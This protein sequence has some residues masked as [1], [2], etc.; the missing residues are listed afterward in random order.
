MARV[1]FVV[2]TTAE[3]TKAG[4]SQAPH[5]APGANRGWWFGDKVCQLMLKKIVTVP[6]ISVA[7]NLQS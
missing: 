2:E 4:G 1:L 3:D 6:A 7:C 5:W